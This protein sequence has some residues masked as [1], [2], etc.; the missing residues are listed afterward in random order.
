MTC[1]HRPPLRDDTKMWH[2]YLCLRPNFHKFWHGMV[3][4]P[5]DCEGY[6]EADA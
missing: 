1:K 2:K 3:D 6:E 5:A 4:C